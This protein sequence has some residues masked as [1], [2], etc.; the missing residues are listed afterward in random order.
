MF[1]SACGD[2]NSNQSSDSALSQVLSSPREYI[3]QP[4]IVQ[5]RVREIVGLNSFILAPTSAGGDG[6]SGN[7]SG[8]PNA[9]STTQE[10]LLVVR[11]DDLPALRALVPVEVTRVF[12]GD[13]LQIAGPLVLFDSEHFEEVLKDDLEMELLT[14]RFRAEPAVVALIVSRVQQQSSQRG[15]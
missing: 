12:E 8:G 14:A 1:L 13:V 9:S 6:S 10:G 4:I 7:Q 5:G 11:A 3:D 15:N 2:G